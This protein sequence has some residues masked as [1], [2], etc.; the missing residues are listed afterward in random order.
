MKILSRPY[1]ADER[2]GEGL[3]LFLNE[4]D[5]YPIEAIASLRRLAWW[6]ISLRSLTLRELKN[7]VGHTDYLYKLKTKEVSSGTKIS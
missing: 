4:I 7:I 1:P 2:A 3:N 6:H 5:S